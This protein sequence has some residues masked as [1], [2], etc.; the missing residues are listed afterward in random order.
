MKSNQTRNTRR[1]FHIVRDQHG[2]VKA[3][4]Y[5]KNHILQLAI[6]TY[7]NEKN[8]EFIVE[9]LNNSSHDF[10]IFK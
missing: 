7:L 6:G 10:N 5:G 9:A 3:I 2:F 8:S 4:A 1:K